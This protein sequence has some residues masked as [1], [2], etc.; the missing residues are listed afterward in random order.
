SAASSTAA[1]LTTSVPSTLSTRLFI[2]D[3]PRSTRH[4]GVSSDDK[5]RNQSAQDALVPEEPLRSATR[6]CD[7]NVF[8]SARTPSM[9]RDGDGSKARF[10]L[11]RPP[12][13]VW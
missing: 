7:E 3:A 8:S 13:A 4:A 10:S 6:T 9:P 5:G 1:A 2:L 11:L 12:H